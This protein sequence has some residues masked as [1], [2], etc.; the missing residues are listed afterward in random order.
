MLYTNYA[1]AR[2]SAIHHVHHFDKLATIYAK[3]KFI[4]FLCNVPRGAALEQSL[5]K[6][7]TNIDI[8]MKTWILQ[9]LSLPFFYYH[10]QGRYG[11]QF[12]A[13]KAL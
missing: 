11:S 3:Y 2:N 7:S 6:V 1:M 5:C 12:L 13:L 10:V 4:F 8:L 9:N